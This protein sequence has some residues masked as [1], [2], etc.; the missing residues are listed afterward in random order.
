MKLS[1]LILKLSGKLTELGDLEVLL[2]I[3]DDHAGQFIGS[4]LD[5]EYGEGKLLIISDADTDF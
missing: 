5:L 4:N 3:E 2:A 1:D